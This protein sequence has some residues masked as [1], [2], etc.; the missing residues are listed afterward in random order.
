MSIDL[1]A[2]VRRAIVPLAVAI[3]VALLLLP[4]AQASE[5]LQGSVSGPTP[6][7][8]QEKTPQPPRPNATNALVVEPLSATLTPEDLA[9]NLVGEGIT[10]SGA[11]YSGANI[12]AGI[13]SG[14]ASIVG[15]DTG[16]LLTSGSVHNT[17]GPNQL[18][19]VTT[20]NGTPGDADLTALAGFTTFDAS[21]LEFDF[22][23]ATDTVFFRFVFASDEYNEFVTTQFNDVFAFFVNGTNCATVEGD[24]VSINTI[25]FGRPYGSTPN[26]H[27]ELYINN[28]LQ[29]GG[30]SINT[31]MDG[32]THVLTCTATVTA[33]ATNHLKLAIADASDQQWD[34]AVFL[35]AESLTGARV[36]ELTG[37]E[38]TQAIQ[39]LE[40]SVALIKDKPAFVR[41]HVRSN[42]T[43]L[44]NVKARLI[45]RRGGQVLPGSPLA[46]SNPGGRINVG[47][48]PNRG[49]LNDSF[50]FALPASW[51]NGTVE[52]Q[53]IGVTH[54]PECLDH[55]NTD[56][57]CKAQGTFV[58]MPVPEVAILGIL[59][60]DGGGAVHDPGPA[61]YAAVVT[62][63]EAQYPIADLNWTN[64]RELT[65][66]GNPPDLNTLLTTV[67]NQR[68]MDGST[69][70]YY[71]LLID[72]ASGGLGLGFTPGSASVGYH[73]AVDPTTAA[74]EIGHNLGRQHTNCSGSEAGADPGFPHP[75]GRISPVL[76]G[77]TALFGFH[78]TTQQIF[79]PDNGDLL[80]YCRPRWVS[81]HTYTRL[82]T[83]IDGR[84]LAAARE[85]TIMDAGEPAVLVSGSVKPAQG[86]GKFATILQL[87]APVDLVPPPSGPY[88]LRFEG[89]GGAVL[90][91]YTFTPNPVSDG[92]PQ[93]LF[94]LLLPWNA[95]TQKIV[96]LQGNKV[97]DQRAA[98]GAAPTVTLT[99]PTPG[100]N[101]E[102]NGTANIAWT[103]SPSAQEFAIQYS[104]D[105]GE[106]W[107]TL[108]TGLQG[109]S[110][111]VS[112]ASLGGSDSALLRVLAS[113]G[114]LTGMDTMDGPFSVA[115]HAPA[116][117]INAP[118][119]GSIF[120]TDQLIIFQG[121]GLDAEDGLMDDESLRWSSSEDG[122]L[123]GGQTL[124]VNAN[125]LTPGEH[126]ITL[127]ATDSGN[128]TGQ[129]TVAIEVA[130]DDVELPKQLA[131]SPDDAAYE[132]ALDADEEMTLAV[133]VRNL[134]SGTIEWEAESDAPWLTL[135]AAS[136]FTPADLT[137]TIDST[138]LLPGV[139][140]GA[141][142]FTGVDAQDSPQTVAVE[143]TI[144][145]PPTIYV[146]IVNR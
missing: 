138:G 13:F 46:P 82:R 113:D 78:I 120:V 54:Q 126:V 87:P 132:V 107:Q 41:A 134:G 135:S 20:Q 108:I 102:G 146:P 52:F 53:F 1:R 51:L 96:L 85:R 60:T 103:A 31:E 137:L 9:A 72:H 4:A 93:S 70:I 56:N 47:T 65:V 34:A 29:D 58:E 86:T 30:G 141:V 91:T 40:N 42:S 101:W 90:A 11:T 80:G 22:V 26:S 62:N 67:N 19:N 118:S 36:L 100:T 27:P 84:W 64:P 48:A 59:W 130:D 79:P 15:F 23:P 99:A 25:N 109:K 44:F 92:S 69:R 133:I 24:P 37:L 7:Q 128:N 39:N 136:G 81:D 2:V 119:A 145:A 105:G 50:Y 77:D 32:L 122:D 55:A 140:Q 75:G 88:T 110:Y 124:E 115:E 16:V 17:V 45:G 144:V 114:F 142:T 104:R 12:A 49:A 28:D 66:A 10:I 21:I 95:A 57:D 97:L 125:D 74:H 6:R 121:V 117:V 98:H 35:E 71:G 129:A 68:T 112:L 3:L 139:Y 43:T 18:D 33:G 73:R 106:T 116:A 94:S 5:S 111:Q 83:A 8:G 123:G 89:A 76:T 63:I 14:G 131:V 61:D 38:I 127:T 143:L